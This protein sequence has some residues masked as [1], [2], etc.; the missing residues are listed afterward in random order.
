[1][2][3]DDKTIKTYDDQAQKWAN[4]I[5]QGKNT[6]HEHLEKPAMYGKLPNLTDKSILCIGCGTGEEC[7]YLK[8]AGARRVVGI[9]LSPG[10]IEVAK[11]TY[12]HL[13]FLVMDMEHLNFEENEFEYVYSSLTMHYVS[14]WRPTF[15]SIKKV[16]KNGGMFLFSTHHPIKWG[17]KV[18]RG[19]QE[20]KFVLGYVKNKDT[21]SYEVFGDY[22]NTRQVSD[23]WYG[24][25]QVSFYHKPLNEILK[26]I[27]QSN[28][29]LMDFL[30]PKATESAISVKPNFYHIHQKIPLY[31]IFEL[32]NRK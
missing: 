27:R 4:R 24:E 7:D 3:T 6:S 10:L 29:E 1:M 28:F 26:E 21:K 12:P 22:L 9:D 16:L 15:T 19:D 23:L 32:K 20:D 11:K 25:M 5:R 30:E 18:E 31:M 8:K 13:E 2:P 14:D 17:A